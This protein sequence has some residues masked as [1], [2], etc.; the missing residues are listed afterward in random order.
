M[1]Y[2]YIGKIV[3]T[4][5]LKGEVKVLSDTDFKEERYASKRAIY[6]E[7]N[8]K[9]IPVF[10]RNFKVVGGTDLL[11]FEGY[12]DINLVEEFIGCELYS[13]GEM[14][15]PKN[16]NEFHINDLL[17]VAVYQKNSFKGKVKDVRNYPQGDY[18]VILKENQE[19][20]LVPF[21]DEFVLS[22]NLDENR[23]D[24]VDLEGLL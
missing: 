8:G 6:I 3:S 12:E 13:E 5:G 15:R 23:I 17:D 1:E 9:K 16:K 21:R 19:T 20:A 10:V 4:R 22:V 14:I 7:K 11:I 24:V 18:L 2:R